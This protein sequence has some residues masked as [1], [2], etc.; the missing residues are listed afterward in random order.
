MHDSVLD[1]GWQT[2]VLAVPFISML[3][4]G[5]FHV[6]ELF[7]A[8]KQRARKPWPSIRIGE[9]GKHMLC[10]PDGRPSRVQRGT[11]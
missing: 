11:K 8:Q 7:V 9:D 1:A 2:G 3:L 6:D 10:D 4:A 5:V